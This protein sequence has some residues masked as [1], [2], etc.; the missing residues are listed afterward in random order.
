MI[1]CNNGWKNYLEKKRITLNLIYIPRSKKLCYD[2]KD[3]ASIGEGVVTSTVAGNK[4][5]VATDLHQV[6]DRQ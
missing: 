4:L 3:V 6:S 1:W 2:L 5:L